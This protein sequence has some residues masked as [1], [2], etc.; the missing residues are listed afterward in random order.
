VSTVLYAMSAHGGVTP[1]HT[2]EHRLA[3]SSEHGRRTYART[4]RRPRSAL[5]GSPRVASGRQA[6]PEPVRDGFESSQFY[7]S[8]TVNLIFFQSSNR[9][10][11]QLKSN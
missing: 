10:L 1:L 9:D 4:P 5:L 8:S 11:S 7:R 2:D 6:G 3:N